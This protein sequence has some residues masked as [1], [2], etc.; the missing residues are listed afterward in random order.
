[1]RET[2]LGHKRIG[3]SHP[4]FVIAE[5]GVNHNGC[6]QTAFR[7]VEAAADAGADAVKFQTF[8]AKRLV[9]KGASKAPYQSKAM[10]EGGSQQEM[11]ER[12]Q[13]SHEDFLA[14]KGYAE[15]RRILFLSTPFDE[16]SADFLS[17]H[18]VSALKIGSGD[19][20]NFPFLEHVASKGCLVICSTGMCTLKEVQQAVDVLRTAGCYDLVLLHCVSNYPARSH[21]VNLLAISTLAKA[22]QVPIGFSDH[23]LGDEIAIAAVALGAKVL[24]K[25]LTLD[26][27][28]FGPDHAVSLHPVAFK[29]FVEKIRSV[30]GALGDGEK[31]PCERELIMASVVRRSIVAARAIPMGKE[32]S[33]E[34]VVMMRPGTGLGA[35][36]R[37]EIMGRCSKVNIP[38]GTLI[39]LEMIE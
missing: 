18:N 3:T 8:D 38:A 16:A 37:D 27:S 29:H 1:M 21:E 31:R 7:L 33:P 12:L 24:E 36:R 15:E 11:L 25:H 34:D 19:I 26:P 2:L 20:T 9:T 17:E 13:L 14:L 5:A 10:G 22:F 28:G 4:C 6:L 32:L 23:T 39:E 35:N 30:E